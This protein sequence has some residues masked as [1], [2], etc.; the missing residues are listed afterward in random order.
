MS[1]ELAALFT[2]PDR[3]AF[4]ADLGKRGPVTQGRYLDGTPIWL[5]TGY[6]ESLAALT[7][8]RLS[9]DIARQSRLDVA[10]A[11]GLPEDVR[12]YLMKTLGAYDPPDHTRLRKLLS[13]EFTVRRV[14]G[15]RPRIQ[16]IVDELLDHIA[17]QD[18]AD[19]IESFAYPLP[20]RVICELLGVPEADRDA[21]RAWSAALT[22]ANLDAIATGAREL[23]RYMFRL[24]E[25]KRVQPG[26]DL[27]SALANAQDRLSDEELT[28]VA[29]TILM[30]GHETTVS[31]I[32]SGASLLLTHPEQADRLRGDADAMA[33][34]VEEMLRHSGPA[35][36]AP[37]RFTLEPV[38]IGGVTIPAGEAVQI[39]NATANRDPRRFADPDRLQLDRPDNQH[40]SF[41]HGI[42]FCLG[43]ALARA[44]A[45]IALHTLLTR[46]PS[47]RL[48]V[49]A[50]HITWQPGLQRALSALPVRL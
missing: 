38:D 49:P 24:I 4:L 8:P 9:S 45:Q 37:M 23:V 42:H 22:A 43:A 18:E 40:L 44:E 16:Q 14:H 32:S 29:I 33:V 11:A 1:I 19:L 7:D 46:L 35:E 41:G 36:I 17:G 2:A 34:A 28:S 3:D 5:V 31:L 21:W 47:V 15:L 48:A 10:A 30:A 39:V 50:E 25:A 12:P 20:I 26:D 6:E 13:R 27:L